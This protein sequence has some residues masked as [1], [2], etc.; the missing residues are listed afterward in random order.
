MLKKTIFSL[1]VFL[2]TSLSFAQE[3]IKYFDNNWKETTQ[4][5]A[6]YYRPLPL[7]KKGN[8]QLLRDFYMQNKAM[9]MQGYYADG[10]E[11][12]FVGELFWYRSDGE[13][14]YDNIYINKS[15]QKK[16]SY[17]FD[18]GTLWK[19]VEYGD[20]LK[21]GKTVELKTD[22]S[23]LGESI[24]KNGHLISG[25]LG[26]NYNS[27]NY[28]RYNKKTKNDESVDL[29]DYKGD[30]RNYSTVYYWKSTLKTAVEFTYLNGKLITEKN[31]DE[32]GNL[33]Q[34]IDSTSYFKNTDELKNGREYF[35]DTYKSG[36][37]L[38]PLFIEYRSYGFSDV[39]LDYISHLI[40][41]RG[42]IHFLEKHPE[43]N[44]YR[45][46]EYNFFK[47][48][49]N[50]F[51]RL[52]LNFRSENVWETLEKFLDE[53]TQLIPVSEIENYS[54]EKIF[55]KFSQK[56]WKN[57]DLKNKPIL[58]ELYF[59]SPNFMEKK[60]K[61]PSKTETNDKESALIYLNIAPGKYV[62]FRENGGYFI[63]KITGDIIE[64]PNFIL[65]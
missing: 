65:N 54:K 30:D 40:L 31:F 4:K 43:K 42:T 25:I 53:E 41:Y 16:L 21:N 57:K 61:T 6:F 52:K 55:E 38:A 34:Q 1:F 11:K 37:K 45:L 56:T 19:T 17:Y 60:L 33:L 44:L 63:P 39:K 3:K 9:Q 32:N 12:N 47:E 22:G 8:L 48:N 20:S 24:Y 26:A 29:P 5:K 7:L 13:D 10:I 18:D 23:L 2:F 27:G 15:N 14:N 46:T 58:E 62:L 49:E 59:A 36:I 28:K 50:H 35:Y 64:I 51:M